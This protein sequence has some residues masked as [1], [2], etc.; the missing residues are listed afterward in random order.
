LDKTI[1][2]FLCRKIEKAS[3]AAA[4][5][6]V[7]GGGK[8]KLNIPKSKATDLVLWI[9]WPAGQSRLIR[10]TT[11]FQPVN[12]R[13]PI[14]LERARCIPEAA[15]YCRII[16]SSNQTTTVGLLEKARR[17][18]HSFDLLAKREQLS[19]VIRANVN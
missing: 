13:F 15:S 2:S 14:H 5:I 10:M 6:A 4:G 18:G 7:R 3:H 1:L 16:L 19:S 12:N 8:N 11:I 9:S 17:C